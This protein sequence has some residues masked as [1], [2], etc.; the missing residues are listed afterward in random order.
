[1]PEALGLRLVQAQGDRMS[2]FVARAVVLGATL[3]SA[4]VVAGTGPLLAANPCGVKST[5]PC[6]AKN[7]CAVKN[8]C[9]AKPPTAVKDPVAEAA[10]KQYKGWKKVN[11]APVLS[12][13]HGNRY[14]FTYLNKTAEPS[15]LQGKFPFPKGS[16]LAKESFEGEDGKPGPRGPLFI[17]EKRGQG[18]DRAH[19]NWHYAVVEPA[20]VISM[21][22]SGHERSSTQFCAACH[23]MAKANDYVFGNG[24]IMKVKPTAMGAPTGNPA[25]AKNPCAPKK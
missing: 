22:G 19:A 15:G 1:M 6:A 25:P 5:N 24:T 8:P 17:M 9:A 7:P 10:S 21:S 2:R 20:G 12:A 11:T 3:A 16:M 23:A 4:V 14:V 18:Y 13:T